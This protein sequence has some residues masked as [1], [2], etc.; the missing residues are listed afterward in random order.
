MVEYVDAQEKPDAIEIMRAKSMVERMQKYAMTILRSP[1]DRLLQ[2][3]ANPYERC[4]AYVIHSMKVLV[5]A[6]LPTEELLERHAD[7]VKM[8]TEI[9]REALEQL[10]KEEG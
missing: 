5:E 4:G 9:K 10:D 2:K 6:R 8:I 1:V 7:I 3:K